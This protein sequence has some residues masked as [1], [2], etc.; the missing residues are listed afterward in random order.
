[1]HSDKPRWFT[2]C[3]RNIL[4]KAVEVVPVSGGQNSLYSE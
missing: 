4:Q 3:I 1:M 2:W